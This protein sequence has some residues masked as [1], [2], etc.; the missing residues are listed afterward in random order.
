[1]VLAFDAIRDTVT[2]NAFKAGES[3]LSLYKEAY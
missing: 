1:M 3:P 2:L